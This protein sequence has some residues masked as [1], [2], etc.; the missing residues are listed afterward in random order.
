MHSQSNFPYRSYANVFGDSYV[1]NYKSNIWN[2]VADEFDS[3]DRVYGAA[4]LQDPNEAATIEFDGFIP[5]LNENRGFNGI[6]YGLI[7][8]SYVFGGAAYQ[9]G[10]H[11]YPA[12][13]N[14]A[15]DRVY[16]TAMWANA[17]KVCQKA[18]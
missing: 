9:F 14:N 8:D 6:V 7:E 12:G 10:I 13:A 17:D 4:T 15:V 2:H 3:S 11:S 16:P 18:T 1:Y 5:S